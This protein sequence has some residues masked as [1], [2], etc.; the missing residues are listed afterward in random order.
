M[1]GDPSGSCLRD[2][3]IEMAKNFEVAVIL[4]TCKSIG[5][6][7]KMYLLLGNWVIF[8]GATS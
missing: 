2:P 4:S 5:I 6:E 1:L 3:S 8:L 7:R